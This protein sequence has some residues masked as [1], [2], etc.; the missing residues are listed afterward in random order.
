MDL[1]V[2]LETIQLFANGLDEDNPGGEGGVSR[3]LAAS[4][5]SM[6]TAS[7]PSPQTDFPDPTGPEADCP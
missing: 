2:G 7:C 4:L 5:Q 1:Q 3:I 6:R